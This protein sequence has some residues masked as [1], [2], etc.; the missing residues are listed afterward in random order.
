[1]VYCLKEIQEQDEKKK[2]LQL[3]ETTTSENSVFLPSS[4]LLLNIMATYSIIRKMCVWARG[5]M[6]LAITLAVIANTGWYFMHLGYLY[7]RN[8]RVY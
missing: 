1:M 5:G 4:V 3:G 8:Y 2:N 7:I 6:T